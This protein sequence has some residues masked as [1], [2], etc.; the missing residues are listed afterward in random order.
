MLKHV[1]TENFVR[2]SAHIIS[3]IRG[4]FRNL[5]FN[6]DFLNFILSKKFNY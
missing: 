5:D 2:I 6:Y 1:I 4:G 3:V